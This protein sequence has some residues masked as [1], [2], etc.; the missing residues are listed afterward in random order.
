MNTNK[1][2]QKKY[3]ANKRFGDAISIPNPHLSKQQI[4]KLIKGDSV[5]LNNV[6]IGFM[7]YLLNNKLIKEA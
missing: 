2:E 4:D 7:D 1:K 5:D 3:K 6:T